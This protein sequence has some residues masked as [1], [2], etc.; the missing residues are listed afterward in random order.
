M[1]DYLLTDLERCALVASVVELLSRLL[2]TEG[3]RPDDLL[4]LL[5]KLE[6]T[7]TKVTVHRAYPPR[8][9]EQ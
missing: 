6:G 4:S 5:A 1:P 9:V 2:A 8:P 7:D 3:H